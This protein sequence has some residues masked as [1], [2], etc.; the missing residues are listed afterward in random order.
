MEQD[1][2]ATPQ[3]YSVELDAYPG[4][5]I[6]T[7][8][9]NKVIN[10]EQT[11]YVPMIKLSKGF[12]VKFTKDQK[13]FIHKVI[14]QQF[15]NYEEGDE[16]KFKDGNLY[17]YNK[18]NLNVIKLKELRAGEAI[19]LEDNF[20]FDDIARKNYQIPNGVNEKLLI[21]DMQRTMIFTYEPFLFYL[22]S[23]GNNEINL[24]PRS[25]K[26]VIRILENIVVGEKFIEV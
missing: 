4:F 17:N 7:A 9:P 10:T 22:K 5:E 21:N 26:D 24:E 16:I 3:P 25:E 2:P 20:L 13:E 18:D 19:D 15:L 6:E 23:V 11:E 1:N 12:I 14:A 8:F